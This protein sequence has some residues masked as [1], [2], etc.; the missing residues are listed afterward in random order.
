MFFLR[1]T[2]NFIENSIDYIKKPNKFAPKLKK[3]AK[4]LKEKG[5][6]HCHWRE[7]RPKKA[8][9]KNKPGVLWP[10]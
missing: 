9:N 4:K 3:I 8:C 6:E 5:F 2:Q 10:T 7:N 1:Y